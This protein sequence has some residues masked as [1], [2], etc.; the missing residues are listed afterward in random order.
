MNDLAE[1][2][3]AARRAEAIARASAPNNRADAIAHAERAATAADVAWE[4]AAIWAAAALGATTVDP[5]TL[6]ACGIRNETIRYAAVLAERDGESVTQYAARIGRHNEIEVLSAG[7]EKVADAHPGTPLQATDEAER[8]T[9]LSHL[10]SAM[11][12]W[13]AARMSEHPPE[14][15]FVD[16][17]PTAPGL[18]DSLRRLI[19][20]LHATH[21]ELAEMQSGSG[22]TEW[23]IVERLDLDDIQTLVMT[24]RLAMVLCAAL[25]VNLSDGTPKPA[26]EDERALIAAWASASKEE[27]DPM[28]CIAE[29]A[30]RCAAIAKRIDNASAE[31]TAARNKR[32]G[33]GNGSGPIH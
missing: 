10:R 16:S 7:C 29:I 32:A 23:K 8:A 17:K 22:S 19:Y 33:N 3:E 2:K 1:S 6:E 25:L 18:H 9:A 30:D 12:A 4:R 20:H 5:E 14:G 11:Q 31:E 27:I 21:D 26:T 28:N 15:G 13:A 24:T